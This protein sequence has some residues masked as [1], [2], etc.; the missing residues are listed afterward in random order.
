MFLPVP[1]PM[2]KAERYMGFLG[3]ITMRYLKP[4]S[5]SHEVPAGYSAQETI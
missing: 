3:A 4:E 5:K 1:G 2:R